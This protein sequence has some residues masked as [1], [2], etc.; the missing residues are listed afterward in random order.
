MANSVSIAVPSYALDLRLFSGRRAYNA[1]HS[2]RELLKQSSVCCDV[3]AT[4]AG[5]SGG[6]TSEEDLHT[7]TIAADNL[8]IPGQKLSCRFSGSLGANG[9]TKTARLKFA[10][11][12]LITLA[13]TGSGLDWIVDVTIYVL[14]SS[15]QRI[16][17]K[18]TLEGVVSAVNV[19]EGTVN[20]T[21][22][23]T[24]KIT[25]QTDVATAD[26]VQVKLTEAYWQYKPGVDA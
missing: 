15:T 2:I 7:Y 9:N 17:A 18:G 16:V 13:T 24:L 25:G 11:T 12:T 4:V 8:V 22:A 1:Q 23:G 21:S 6:S 5:L 10:S 14:T 26:D 19:V 20:L 3:T